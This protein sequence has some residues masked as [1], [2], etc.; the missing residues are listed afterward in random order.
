MSGAQLFLQAREAMRII[1]TVLVYRYKNMGLHMKLELRQHISKQNIFKKSLITTTRC[2]E[3]W[4]ILRSQK[5]V[6]R[7]LERSRMFRG[8]R[9][10]VA[11]PIIVTPV[12]SPIH[13]EVQMLT[14]DDQK[15]Q[16]DLSHKYLRHIIKSVVR[17]WKQNEYVNITLSKVTIYA[18]ALNMHERKGEDYERPLF[19]GISRN[20]YVTNSARRECAS[21]QSTCSVLDDT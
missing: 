12:A 1:L 19:S 13:L 9:P 11:L 10:L 8:V 6:M 7:C 5:E 20:A 21:R 2:R 16:H 18:C 14:S 3:H 15:M 17:L 4:Y